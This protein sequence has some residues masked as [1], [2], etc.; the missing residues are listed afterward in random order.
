[1]PTRA[2]WRG[3]LAVPVLAAVALAALGL[4]SA[5]AFDVDRHRAEA[6]AVQRDPDVIT[7]ELLP[8]PHG[9][10]PG[11]T[12]RL[13]HRPDGWLSV[14][15]LR[16]LP[17]TTGRERYLVF[18][19]NWSGWALAGSVEA[20]A[21]GGAQVRFGAEPRARTLYEAVVTR[22]VDNAVNIPHG[23]PVLHWFDASLGPRRAR[24]FDFAHPRS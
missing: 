12:G 19:R 2:S 23:A 24:P 20:G 1:M 13:Q 9:A 4:A 3:R 14:V 16:G 17:P 8:Y 18:L 21:G 11:S 10:A 5:R 6:A 7:R 22:D 15:T